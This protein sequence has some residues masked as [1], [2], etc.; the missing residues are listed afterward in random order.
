[1]CL[2]RFVQFSV[3][4][5]VQKK[6]EFDEKMSWKMFNVAVCAAGGNCSFG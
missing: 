5:L 4:C 2:G 6:K 1:M 3:F